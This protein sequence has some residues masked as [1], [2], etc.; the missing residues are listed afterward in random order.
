MTEN[1]PDGWPEMYSAAGR[2]PRCPHQFHWDDVE[3]KYVC[4]FCEETENRPP[5]TKIN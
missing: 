2:T 5:E 3:E 4:M 1:F